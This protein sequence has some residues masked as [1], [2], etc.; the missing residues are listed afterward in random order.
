[1]A[2]QARA[3][4]EEGRDLLHRVKERLRNFSA[5]VLQG[6]LNETLGEGFVSKSERKI[7][8]HVSVDGGLRRP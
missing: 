4:F 5:E 1:M 6:Q 3:R 8:G 2:E 7:R